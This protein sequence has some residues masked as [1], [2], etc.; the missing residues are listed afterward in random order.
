MPS[1]IKIIIT[2]CGILLS[3]SACSEI[4]Q[5]ITPTQDPGVVIQVEPTITSTAIKTP[6]DEIMISSSPE[7]EEND[8]SLCGEGQLID[9]PYFFK[10]EN[11]IKS[12][13]QLVRI[14]PTSDGVRRYASVV[15]CLKFIDGWLS[16]PTIVERGYENEI[17]FFDKYGKGHSY[18]IIIGG[19]YIVP[20]DPSHK[21]ITASMNG[22]N[23]DFFT[24]EKWIDIT[25]TQFIA[26]GSRQ[27]GVK[28]YLDDIVGNHSGVFSKVYQFRDTNLLIEEALTTGEGYPDQVPEGFFLFAT[29]T[30]LL[31]PD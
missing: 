4:S 16:D 26:M 9:V 23:E 3:L 2:I 14:L 1:S 12:P 19:H 13:T 8:Y 5:I 17:I 31:Q 11:G 15:S 20:Y 18:R 28:V 22:I 29:K 10:D 25:S 24:V 27:I 30:W 21:D 7:F 6:T